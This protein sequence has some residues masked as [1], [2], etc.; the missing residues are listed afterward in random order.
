MSRFIDRSLNSS[1]TGTSA[2]LEGCINDTVCMKKLLL[3][4]YG[5][6]ESQMRVLNE[7][8]GSQKPVKEAII[9]SLRWLV[10]VREPA[11]QKKPP[12]KPP[13][14]ITTCPT[15]QICSTWH[16]QAFTPGH[17]PAL[18]HEQ[19][20]L[21]RRCTKEFATK[22]NVPHPTL[23]PTALHHMAHAG[24]PTGP[25]ACPPLMDDLSPAT[26]SAPSS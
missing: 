11:P 1:Y 14:K 13:E 5:F 16:T 17:R 15:R 4:T 18:T 24:F 23:D 8:Q 21:A 9:S 6:S 7:T 12:E 3:E 20:S 22:N 2:E 26:M 19:P 25:S 10:A